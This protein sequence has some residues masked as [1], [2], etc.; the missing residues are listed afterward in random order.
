M[1]HRHTRQILQGIDNALISGFRDVDRDVP[2]GLLLAGTDDI[3]GYYITAIGT[4]R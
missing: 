3:D 4:D 1:E 2:G